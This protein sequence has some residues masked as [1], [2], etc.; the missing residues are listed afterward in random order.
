[1]KK[2]TVLI[3]MTVLCMGAFALSRRDAFNFKRHITRISRAAVM[4]NIR[5]FTIDDNG[6]VRV[7]LRDES[8]KTFTKK[9]LDR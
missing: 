5:S 1:M 9:E 3:T 6:N 2:A 4:L 8:V 7:T